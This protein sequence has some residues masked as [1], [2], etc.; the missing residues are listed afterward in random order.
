MKDFVTLTEL[1]LK[2][3]GL[4]WE[5]QNNGYRDQCFDPLFFNHSKWDNIQRREGL[6]NFGKLVFDFSVKLSKRARI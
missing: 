3:S 2:K 4:S 6:S 1:S 5:L